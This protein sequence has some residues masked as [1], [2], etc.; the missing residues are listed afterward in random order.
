MAY[1]PDEIWPRIFSEFEDRL[2]LYNWRVGYRPSTYDRPDTTLLSLSLVSRRFAR[3]AQNL[4]YRT[5]RFCCDGDGESAQ[6]LIL[7]SLATNPQLGQNTRA[8]SFSNEDPPE[9]FE[10][11]DYLF[12]TSFPDVLEAARASLDLP[13]AFA[14]RLDEMLTLERFCSGL[15][16]LVLAFTPQVQLVDVT[17]PWTALDLEISPLSWMLSGSLAVEGDGADGDQRGDNGSQVFSN[18][19]LPHLRDVQLRAE[20]PGKLLP[21]WQ[22][23][24]MLL[25]PTLKTLRT[26]FVG[27][28]R[29]DVSKFK[30]PNHISNLEH[31]ELMDCSIDSEGLRSVLT[32]CT[33][34]RQLSIQLDRVEGSAD[35]PLPSGLSI[36]LDEFGNILREHGRGLVSLD[37]D[38][39][40]YRRH[41]FINGSLGPLRELSS[42]RHL[43]VVPQD[44]FH[45]ASCSR[46]LPLS[47][48][49]L[50][51][52]EYDLSDPLYDS[53]KFEDNKDLARLVMAD[54]H[55]N[56]REI[57]AVGDYDVAPEEEEWDADVPLG[58]EVREKRHFRMGNNEVGI[59][60]LKRI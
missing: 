11:I 53:G 32:R 55:P 49:T 58:G 34:L 19:G 23:E 24:P 54:G 28:D 20:N 5:L 36:D 16:T 6:P 38:T 18:Y 17:I 2:P 3:L 29:H 51:L 14:R 45:T 30:W 12:D 50:F 40:G 56:L 41:G 43:R 42:L 33:N 4:L 59:L 10:D 26:D 44:L 25:H 48:E 37:L 57:R 31:L 8:I 1:I 60:V 39:Q 21:F 15:D 35:D 9:S 7:Q 22:I 47:L 46:S 52:N 13:P 27:W